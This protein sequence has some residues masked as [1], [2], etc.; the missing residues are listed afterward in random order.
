MS[1]PTY[2][3]AIVVLNEQQSSAKTIS[4]VEAVSLND[5][6]ESLQLDLLSE[7][8]ATGPGADPGTTLREISIGATDLFVQAFPT[9]TEQTNM[10][11]DNVSGAIKSRAIARLGSVTVSI[12]G[13]GV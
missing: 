11:K 4:I 13:G 3:I 9:T 8:D 12:A 7:T 2:Q 1:L 6:L 5:V 10:I